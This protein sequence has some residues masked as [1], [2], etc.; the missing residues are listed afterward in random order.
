MSWWR[1]LYLRNALGLPD[2]MLHLVGQYVQCA[3]GNF[4][5]RM[6]RY[7]IDGDDE[8]VLAEIV[9]LR[10][11]NYQNFWDTYSGTQSTGKAGI[12]L[13]SKLSHESGNQL[14]SD[15]QALHPLLCYRLAKL[16]ETLGVFSLQPLGWLHQL[17]A[18]ISPHGLVALFDITKPIT[19]PIEASFIEQLLEASAESA[20]SLAE[21]VYF[22][23]PD[24]FY[25]TRLIAGACA[26]LQGFSDYSLQHRDIVREALQQKQS[27]RRNFVLE[28]LIYRQVS[29]EP[30]I[31]LVVKM[32]FSP[33]KGERE[34]AAK[35]L[36]QDVKQI[37]PWVQEKAAHGTV[38]ER[39]RAVQILWTLQG[40]EA[41]PF[42]EARLPL[43]TA[44]KAQQSIQVCLSRVAELPSEC[45]SLELPSLD[46]IQ[47][48][49]PLPDSI[50]KTLAKALD[51]L[52]T[53]TRQFD[54]AFIEQCL[55]TGTVSECANCLGSTFKRNIH[56]T[57]SELKPVLNAILKHPHLSFLHAF[58]LLI[59]FGCFHRNFES[60]LLSS[61][62][63]SL[64]NTYRQSHPEMGLRE[65]A[66][67]FKVLELKPEQLGRYTVR[68]ASQ[69][70]HEHSWWGKE[71]VWP[72]F[73]EYPHLL[74]EAFKEN[75]DDWG[76]TARKQY[77]LQILSLFPQLPSSLIPFLW[78]LALGNAK[79]ERPFAQKC[80]NAIPNVTEQLLQT[81]QR[82]DAASRAIAA[83]WLANRNDTAAISPLKEL[84]L[85]E[86][87]DAAKVAFMRSL[88]HLGAPIDEFLNRD[89][90][91]SDA[92]KGLTKG[93][94]EALSW[95]PFA[96]LPSVH[97]TDNNQ[98]IDPM[99][100]T[101]L[102][103]QGYKQKS[104]EPSPLLQR[105]AQLWNASDR[106]ALGSFVL[107]H[108]SAQDT[109]PSHTQE[110]AE[111]LARKNAQTYGQYYPNKTQE[112][113]Y[114]DFLNQLLEECKGSAI[115]E[116]GILAIAAACIMGASAVPVVKKYLD[117]WY[118]NRAAQCNALLQMLSWIED[119][120]SIQYLLSIAS[121]FRT[122]SIQKEADKL[123][124]AI[125]DRHQWTP[126][127]LGDRT[128][129]TAGLNAD[130]TLTLDYGSRQFTLTLNAGL[131][132]I[133]RNTDDKVL[134]TL[135]NANQQ[136]DPALAEAAKAAFSQTKKEL[137]Q[138]LQI[139]K[140]RL[141]EAMTVQRSW[142]Y[143][144][145]ESLL[146][147]HPIL[148]L[149]TQSL[150]WAVF[151]DDRFVH[152][153]RPLG[154]GTLTTLDDREVTL[155][156]ETVLRLAHTSLVSETDAQAWNTHLSDYEVVPPFA[157]F[158]TG[159]YSIPTDPQVTDL[160]DFH[161]HTLEAFHLRGRATKR[162]Y[163]RG[164]TGDGGYFG[165]YHKTFSS[166]GIEAVIDFSGNSLPEENVPVQLYGLYFYK[167]G[168]RGMREI[169]D[170]SDY[171]KLP[172]QSV[173]PVLLQECWNDLRHIAA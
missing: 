107:N 97:W 69:W 48:D 40:K 58:R 162:G 137:K 60:D 166:V 141:Y 83:E 156:P 13:F 96:D 100:L 53:P 71:S 139:Q 51:G 34:L 113:I 59:L 62:F 1:S 36:V 61:D 27:S 8:A 164:P 35:Y 160:N 44:L 95:F 63:F 127:E 146:N 91:L 98:A 33:R 128:I 125:A 78:S 155:K 46:W 25:N 75:I 87:S 123:I 10:Q 152:A 143:S 158:W 112:Q 163:N 124:H 117:T 66:A 167:L 153:V 65:L 93:I 55:E 173:P 7:A 110:R 150:V 54:I 15:I 103:V 30:F 161:N 42:L 6:M 136:D 2:E 149:Y 132:L 70:H 9:E 111:L 21:V 106:L 24:D 120:A 122:K 50:R 32:A 73:Y 165:T 67:V 31:D 45:T 138:V 94:P 29:I 118:G 157:Q 52:K 74:E 133:L 130:R 129:P 104:P 172:L 5:E 72:Y 68:Y 121:R 85:K 79:T 77:A 37:I 57:I 64:L 147:Q 14:F 82:P 134:K 38:A 114:R 109:A 20:K 140:T 56:G 43:E 89:Q 23:D 168:D 116:K 41:C 135:P 4:P 105:Y 102:I 16:N 151:E 154:D 108:W 101:W 11:T 88:E 171:A 159:L 84:L 3:Q 126:E 90:L 115:K 80:L 49:S 17:L 76:Y 28:I 144:D 39:D 86:K 169:Y 47:H 12:Q 18:R 92:Q 170:L 22:A 131:N 26:A 145:W 19:L 148:G 99:I 119:N 142:C 81:L